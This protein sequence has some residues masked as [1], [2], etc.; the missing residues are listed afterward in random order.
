MITKSIPSL[1]TVGNL[2]LGIISIMLAFHNNYDLA[3]LMI[4]IAMLLDG[5]DGRVARALNAQSEFGKELDSLSDVIS[6][7]VAP[8]FIMYVVAFSDMN[9]AL[10]WVVTAIFPICGA[11]RLA[12]FNVKAG[13]PGYF[14]GLPIPAAGG[15]ACT[16]ALFHESIP[17]PYLIIAM[18]LLSY[19]MVSTV[20]YPNFKKVG[21]SK[22]ALWLTPFVI[23]AA[24]GIALWKPEQTPKLIF[25]PLVLY[26]LLGLK[27]NVRMLNRRRGKQRDSEEWVR[28]KHS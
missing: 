9:P 14:I 7:G 8:A 20:K 23:A 17:A 12:R 22:K 26:A 10:G 25:V 1:F 13:I 6:F 4:I 24:V 18:L 3:A 11:L 27:K 15:V 21:I 28:S 19:L 16:L 5:L 2:F